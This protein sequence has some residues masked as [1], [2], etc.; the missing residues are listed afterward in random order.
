MIAA[1]ALFDQTTLAYLLACD[2]VVLRYRAFFAL[3]DWSCI[4]EHDPLHPPPG[5]RPHPQCA[6]V[7]A[8]LVKLCEGKQYA[9]SLRAFLVEHPL[10]VLELDFRPR[11]D[12]SQPYGFDVEHT[13]PSARHLRRKQQ[14]LDHDI[15]TDLLHAT[16]PLL[17]AEIP[18]LGETIAVDV[19]HIYAWVRENNPRQYVTERFDPK[20]QPPG[21]PDCKLGVKRSTNQEQT[22]GSTK[23]KKEYLWGYGSGVTAATTPDY[24]DVVLAEFTQPFNENDVTY[25]EPLYRQAVVALNQYPINVTADAAYDAWYVYEK[26]ARHGGIG[27][28]P[29]NQHGHPTF[30]RET[31]GVPLCPI[32]LRMTPTFTFA[33]TS[34]YRALRYRCPLLFPSPTGQTCAH[35]QFLKGK[36]CVKDVNAEL[37][38]QMRV[39][40]DRTG[41]LYQAIYRQRTSCER[42]NS[43]AKELGI[44]RPRVRNAR[45]IHNLNTLIYIIIN[46]KAIQRVQSINAR[47]LRRE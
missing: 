33:H 17:R 10:L 47:L 32:Q 11:L 2:P 14:V 42:I 40:L 16:I 35:A 18:G 34:G 31:D 12:P 44:E 19:K 5:P 15:F 29:L 30:Q 8:L 38:G 22:D 7:K 27:A 6:Y 21:D 13:V 45:S 36:G 37:G 4:P 26:A 20:Q 28:V 46:A 41:P 1:S 9:T 43:Q 25:F 24:G 39:T 3:L 23:E